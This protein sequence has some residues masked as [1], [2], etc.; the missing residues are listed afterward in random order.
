MTCTRGPK[1]DA[2]LNHS[3]PPP[4][5]GPSSTLR[6]RT[7]KF[8]S[9]V[10]HNR[11]RD[12]GGGVGEEGEEGSYVPY[13]CPPPHDSWDGFVGD[14]LAPRALSRGPR[15]PVPAIG[16]GSCRSLLRRP[17]SVASPVAPSSCY[18]S[19]CWS[20]PVRGGAPVSHAVDESRL[21]GEGLGGNASGYG[22]ELPRRRGPQHARK[23]RR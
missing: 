6:R 10:A 5:I 17:I 4:P 9:A 2:A 8:D 13:A 20:T 22:G 21:A 3:F 11:N 15:R 14:M 12:G 18:L 23:G 16:G 7:G 19:T 1:S